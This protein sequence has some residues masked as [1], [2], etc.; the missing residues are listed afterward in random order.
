MVE[1][2][3]I[4]TQAGFTLIELLVV[5]AII[6]LLA[7]VVLVALNGARLKSR[8][9]KR[10]ADIRQLQTA[11]DLYLSDNNQYPAGTCES[12]AGGANS[13]CWSTLIT[14]TYL[15]KMP[16]D[17]LNTA[18]QYGYYYASGWKPTGPCA[19]SFTNLG[20]DYYIAA[21]LENPSVISG[22]C[23]AGFAALDNGS[24]NYLVGQ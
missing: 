11:L 4:K 17:P 6:G 16:I 21:R 24:L 20:V 3:K 5:I 18:T 22:T 1:V 9:A 2:Y 7:S 13:A 8:D 15:S 10:I 23:S 12:T 19:A 14:S